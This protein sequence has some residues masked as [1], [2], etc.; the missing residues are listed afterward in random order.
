MSLLT[1][2]YEPFNFI[3]KSWKPDGEGG[4]ATVWSEGA[5]FYAH[6]R[7]DKSIQAK[8]AE[9]QGVTSLYTITTNKSLTL[10]KNDVIKR[11]ED[12]ATFRITSNGTDDKTPNSAGLDMRQ[13]SAEL[14][15]IPND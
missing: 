1:E 3:E 14:W 5:E 8:I 2:N 4:F 9:K 6:A 12:G 7:L 15:V 10:V 13:V 11:K